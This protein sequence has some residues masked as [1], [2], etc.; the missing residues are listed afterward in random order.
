MNV[1]SSAPRVKHSPLKGLPPGLQKARLP[2]KG[3]GQLQKAAAPQRP[4]DPQALFQRGF[5]LHQQ[6][7]LQEAQNIYQQVLR[8]NPQHFD[9]LHLGG[10]ILAQT[11]DPAGAAL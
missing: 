7:Q 11:G 2:G 5:A 3:K 6:G 8:L 1:K 10:V 4:E 9:A